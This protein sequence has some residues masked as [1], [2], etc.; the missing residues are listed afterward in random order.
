MLAK[1]NL[2]FRLAMNQID[3]IE[4]DVTA[5]I[6]SLY[7]VFPVIT[8][9]GP[10]QSGKTTLC[11]QMFSGLPYLDFERLDVQHAIMDDPNTFILQYPTGAILD[12]AQRFPDIFSYLKAVVDEDRFQG[13]TEHRYIVSGSSNF[14]LLESISQSMAGRTAVITL[15]PL[16]VREIEK[17]L[18]KIDT[19]RLMIN[20][21]YPA[22]WRNG[23]NQRDDL[24]ANYY[25]TYVERDV[26]RII[27][28]QNLVQFQNFM[29]MCA[30]RV[31]SELN[32]TSIS[33][34]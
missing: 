26:R 10:R 14:S 28:V 18:G 29:I 22:I 24:L 23:D 34:Q 31:G 2:K 1:S 8:V 15:L 33:T 12:E 16:S 13:S 27:N 4:R 6:M 5:K 25:A 20:G 21:G 3:Y 19:D 7:N 11:R 9:T 32:L 30:S 17:S